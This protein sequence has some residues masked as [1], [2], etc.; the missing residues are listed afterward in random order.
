M[1]DWMKMNPSAI[2]KIVLSGNRDLAGMY[3]GE[4]M[5]FLHILKNRMNLGGIE[6]LSGPPHIL[7]DG[8]TIRVSSVYGQDQVIIDSPFP[9]LAIAP[10]GQVEEIKCTIL[11]KNLPTIVQPMKY[12]KEIHSGEVSGTDFI[13]T[14]YTHD[15][16][17]CPECRNI[18]WTFK[19]KYKKPVEPRHWVDP[20]TGIEDINNH[21]VWSLSPP[22]WGEI[23]KHLDNQAGGYIIWKAYT[24]TGE[25][26]S[27]TGLGI[28]LLTAE[29]K[30]SMGNVLCSKKKKID[31][32]CCHK[33]AKI[34]PVEIWWQGWPPNHCQPYMYYKGVAVC[35]MPK[36]LPNSDLYQY[37]IYHSQEGGGG[38][39]L[40]SIAD[41]NGSCLPLTWEVA[42]GQGTM[43]V[44]D[45][46]G[47]MAYY[48]LDLGVN[49]G[50]CYATPLIKL[51]DRCGTSYTVQTTPCC[52]S[53]LPVEI[54]Y[55]SLMMGCGSSQELTG[56]GGCPPYAWAVSSGGGV[57]SGDNGLSV[58]YTAPPTN[59]NCVDNPTITVTDCCGNSANIKLAINC[60]SSAG[61]ALE[62]WTTSFRYCCSYCPPQQDCSKC[63][64]CG[65]TGYRWQH[66]EWNCDGSVLLYYDGGEPISKD[67]VCPGCGNYEW[68]NCADN[69]IAANTCD[70]CCNGDITQWHLGTVTDDRTD[71]MKAAGCCPINPITGLPY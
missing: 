20:V 64:R 65:R 39:P 71:A 17:Q 18:N 28:L 25:P 44:P 3:V 32:D 62:L 63:G 33:D 19:F 52:G 57:L 41:V 30:D 43:N 54:W 69:T 49:L 47:T 46:T 70:P 12:P 2:V 26:Y 55:T 53:E 60:D 50:D 59:A 8:T 24:E 29:I 66:W 61:P 38:G 1:A 37:A 5:N 56:N 6:S 67:I 51:T 22:A 68:V 15:I 21:T 13:K 23:I 35:L 4:A 16:S 48:K 45:K 34:R 31:V 14:Y 10:T 40:Y 11:L 58:V 9:P 27:R 7:P 42:G 36:N